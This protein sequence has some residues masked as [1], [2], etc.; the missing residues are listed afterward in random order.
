MRI[1]HT[2]DWHLGH[3]LYD[4][5]R[6]DEHQ[7][8]LSWLLKTIEQQNID[9]LLICG[10]IFDTT[11]P[12]ITSQSLY[13]T[14]LA[15]VAKTTCRHV[16][17]VGGN[18]DAP[19]F[20]NAPQHLLNHLGI[21][22]VGSAL[23]NLE[24]EILKLKN[25]KGE[26]ELL[27]CAVPFLRD[28]DVRSV[29]EYENSKEK[30]K[31]LIAGIKKHYALV[32]QRALEVSDE[33]P[34]I[35]TGHLFTIGGVGEK[36]EG[37][38]DL[39]VGT[40]VYVPPLAL[41]QKSD[42]IALGHLHT[43]QQIND[44]IFYSGSPLPMSFT[45]QDKDKFVLFVE[46][47]KNQKPKVEPIVVPRFQQLKKLSGDDDA[48]LKNLKELLKEENSIWVE[49]YYEGN[50]GAKSFKE[51]V[52]SLIE[53]SNVELLK[54]SSPLAKEYTLKSDENLEKLKELDPE[55]VF[56]RRLESEELGDEIKEELT[57]L[58]KTVLRTIEEEE[59]L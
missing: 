23:P 15:E 44:T 4:K 42:Y 16:V 39:Y 13:Y 32:E 1:L 37:I 45:D 11:T 7:Q 19:S 31:N 58:Y 6:N 55:E 12:S 47:Q 38:R 35:T 2:S 27:V 29:I 30:D 33:I 41:G 25:K 52:D 43:K 54:F 3:T 46:V 28:R 20:L 48:I 56:K 9:V 36:E 50:L 49:I 40:T 34:L 26:I 17:I 57:L 24:D 5:R 14:F 21:Y 53:N 8:F 22:V 10:D 51:Q 59:H 18:H